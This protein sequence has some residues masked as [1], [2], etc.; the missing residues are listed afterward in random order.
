[1]KKK[2]TPLGIRFE[3][4]INKIFE[5][6][7]F[8]VTN[9]SITHDLG[10]DLIARID[11][12]DCYV[13][14]K[15]Y[16]SKLPKLDLLEAAQ[17]SMLKLQRFSNEV[18]KLILVVSSYVTPSLKDEIFRNTG[19][20]V[21]DAKTLFALSFQ[22]DALY[23]DLGAILSSI[24]GTSVDD[25][26]KVEESDKAIIDFLK[27]AQIPPVINQP[28]EKGKTLCKQLNDI[29]GGQAGYI[30]FEEKCVE[31]LKYLFDNDTDLTLWEEQ[32]RTDDGLH[33]FD[34]LCRIISSN[35]NSFW[36]ELANDFHTRYVVFEFKNYNDQIKQGQVYTTEKYLFLTALRS[37]S[38]II[39]R[40]G[41]D[42][43]AIKAAKGALKEAGKLIVILTPRDICDMLTLKDNG[44]E[45]ADVLRQRIDDMLIHLTR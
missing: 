30:R 23:Y 34:L 33:R 17:N 45:P 29:D 24:L 42:A 36:A 4:V 39:A 16:S 37:V 11:N 41:A 10:Y 6:N 40:N 27:S 43:N 21:W 15:V 9:L 8:W 12:I 38:F 7:G 13:E 3:V 1:M 18:A 20:I 35:Q 5:A 28:D 22:H 2:Y 31:I 14:I 25:L 26:A 44:D 32:P 19:I